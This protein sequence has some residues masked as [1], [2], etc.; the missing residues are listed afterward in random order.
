MRA[1]LLAE[2]PPIGRRLRM[3]RTGDGMTMIPGQP[4]GPILPGSRRVN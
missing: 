4:I 1:V 3:E 2:A